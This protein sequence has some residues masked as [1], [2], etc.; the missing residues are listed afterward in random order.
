M[1]VQVWREGLRAFLRSWTEDDL[2]KASKK[3]RSKG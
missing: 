2:A 1:R 3:L